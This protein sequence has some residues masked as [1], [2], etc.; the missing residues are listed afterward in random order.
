[1]SDL[2]TTSNAPTDRRDKAGRE[3]STSL[4][5][6]V[7][8]PSV[9]RIFFLFRDETTIGR[10]KDANIALDDRSVSRRHA[11][12]RR[13]AHSFVIN[14]LGST[15]C[16]SVNGQKCE[17]AVLKD[18]DRIEIGSSVL[19]FVSSASKEQ[20]YYQEAYRQA[21]MDTVLLVYN[22]PYFL[23]RL[24]EE[25]CRCRRNHNTLSLLLFDADHFKRINDTY[26]HLAGDAALLHLVSLI[27]SNTRRSDALCRYGGEEFAL[28]LPDT[29]KAQAFVIAEHIRSLIART[30]LELGDQTIPITVSVGVAGSGPNDVDLSGDGECL[31][32]AAD[33]ALYRAKQGGR[34]R[35]ES[36]ESA[37]SP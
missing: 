19:K 35:A 16:T 7:Q 31:I 4:L 6:V 22:K 25:L 23:Q 21:C 33:R 32:E 37:E 20:P 1:M 10:A 13:T 36:A 29:E 27:K 14:D 17:H 5:V 24:D 18:Q 26:G 9:G 15:N 8:G 3:Q 28:L 34:N 30:P 11:V 12:V 2:P